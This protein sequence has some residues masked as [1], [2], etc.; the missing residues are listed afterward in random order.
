VAVMSV[1][2]ASAADPNSRDCKIYGICQPNQGPDTNATTSSGVGDQPAVTEDSADWNSRD[3]RRFGICPAPLGSTQSP[4]D[5]SEA[6][7]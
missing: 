2:P 4:S 5:S 7:R 6:Y 3:C 1:A